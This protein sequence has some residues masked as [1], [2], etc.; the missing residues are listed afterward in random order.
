MTLRRRV[1]G[2]LAFAAIASCAL[3]VG[4]AVVLVRQRIAAQRLAALETQAD[5]VAATAGSTSGAFGSGALVYHAGAGRL[6]RLPATLAAQVIAAIPDRSFG[7]GTTSAGGRDYIYA[8]RPAATAGR[9]VLVRAARIAFGEWRPFL[10]SLI[11][12]GLGGALL[13]V[14]LSYLLARRLTRP[15]RDLSM[16]TRQL[17]SGHAVAVPIAGED[18]LAGL[19]V[20]F[21]EMSAE[22]TH[23]RESQRQFLESVSHELKTP[24]TSIRGYAEALVE[25]AV[26]SADGAR[27][28]RAEADRLERL[29]V[30]L[31]DLARLGRP[32][33]SVARDPVDLGVIADQAVERHAPRAQ[34]MG[35]SLTSSQSGTPLALGD[36]DRMLQAVSNLVENALRVTPA[37]GSVVVTA[38]P[39]LL[40]VTDTGP[41]LAEDD[42]PRA[43]ERFYLHRRYRSERPVGSGLGLA[44]VKELMTAM[45]GS[46]DALSVGGGGAQFVLRFREVSPAQARV[47][48]QATR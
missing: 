31:L 26:A 25:D 37:G 35:V 28:I 42:I 18:E 44:I 7:E 8:A 46:V 19:G 15:I 32:G 45:G 11:L 36:E 14:I 16:A 13:A 23:A 2:Y 5:A 6:R 41:G 38:A 30:D 10:A 48:P 24:L 39:A 3:T 21:N 22:L 27:V 12:A 43:F 17:S 4:V 20:A 29:V 33:F 1:L 9:I 47:T 34:E 40:S